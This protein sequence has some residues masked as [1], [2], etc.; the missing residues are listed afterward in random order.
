MSIHSLCALRRV[1]PLVRVTKHVFSD[2][3][4][5]PEKVI[6]FGSNSN[7]KSLYTFKNEK[8]TRERKGKKK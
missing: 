6:V 3:Q 7:T 8:E 2:I 4:E 1:V 5:L